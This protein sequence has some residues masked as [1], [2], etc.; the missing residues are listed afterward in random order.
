MIFNFFNC[1]FKLNII[2]ECYLSFHKTSLIVTK[3]RQSNSYQR[4]FLG[5]Q[6]SKSLRQRGV[7]VCVCV[8]VC[9]LSRSVLSDSATPWTVTHQALLSMGFSRQKYWSGLP[10]P[11]AGDLLDPG[12]KPMS[13]VSLAL[14]GGFFTTETPGK[15]ES[16]YG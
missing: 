12:I 2:Q 9:L 1:N 10:F 5:Y 16:C 11:P 15:P 7:C 14:A 4:D 8:C 3:E 6:S 13:L